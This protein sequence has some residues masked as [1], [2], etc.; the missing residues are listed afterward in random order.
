MTKL[1]FLSVMALLILGSSGVLHSQ[2]RLFDN[3]SISA[4]VTAIQILGNNPA[5]ATMIERDSTKPQ[6]FGGS[7]DG[8]Q[9]GISFMLDFSL[10]EQRKYVIPVGIEHNFFEGLERVPIAKDVTARFRHTNQLTTLK[11]GFRYSF[12]KFP[13]ANVIAYTAL[14]A[15]FTFVH[16][17]DYYQS[18]EYEQYDS[19]EVYEAKTKD[20]ATRIGGALRIGFEGDIY[21]PWY[22]VCDASWGIM[23]LL[24]R[25]DTRGQLLTPNT[26]FEKLVESYVYTFNFQILLQ[27]RF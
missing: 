25:D 8:P 1:R 16:Q 3:V 6:I 22:I 21:E 13:F 24:G 12:M 23:N 2:S 18:I 15:R 20:A 4:G 19:L 11:T 10:D 27:Y 7:F 17:G 5:T 14:D 9:P 26:R